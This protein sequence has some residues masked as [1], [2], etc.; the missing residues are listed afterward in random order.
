MQISDLKKRV[1]NLKKINLKVAD[2]FVN[3]N[4]PK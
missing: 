3:E 4:E 2:T 1:K